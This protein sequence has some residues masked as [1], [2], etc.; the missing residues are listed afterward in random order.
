MLVTMQEFIINVDVDYEGIVWPS[1]TNYP[2]SKIFIW[3]LANTRLL[4]HLQTNCPLLFA[5]GNHP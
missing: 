1:I 2:L 5:P 4:S 3:K